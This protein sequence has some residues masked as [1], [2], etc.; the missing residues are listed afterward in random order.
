MLEATDACFGAIAM[1]RAD[2]RRQAKD[3]ERLLARGIDP[4]SQGPQQTA[5]MARQLH[6]LFERAKR[7]RSIDPPVQYLH[8]RMDATQQGLNDIQV[9]CKKGCAHCCHIWVSV[10]IP[11]VLFVAKALRRRNN[12]ATADKVKAAHLATGPFDFVARGAHPH[13]CPLLEEDLCSVYPIR[14]RACRFAASFDAEICARSYRQ[15]ANEDIPTPTGSVL[16]RNGYAMALAIA[17]KHAQL[18]HHLYEF[19]VALARAME[20]DDAERQWLAGVDVFADVRRDPGDIFADS[21]AYMIY[22]EAFGPA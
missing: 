15:S 2:R 9:A 1:N 14:P 17:L 10:T 12:S 16:A 21:P 8:S 18:P 22:G 13:A 7:E 3:D 11:E 19:H 5:A 20:I 6:A 4:E